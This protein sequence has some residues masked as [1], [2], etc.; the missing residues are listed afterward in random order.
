MFWMLWMCWE[1]SLSF[2]GCHYETASNLGCMLPVKMR[3]DSRWM[4]DMFGCIILDWLF[5]DCWLLL[6]VWLL[7]LLSKGCHYETANNLCCMLPVNKGSDP[8]LSKRYAHL[9]KLLQLEI[10][11]FGSESLLILSGNKNPKLWTSVFKNE[12]NWWNYFIKQ[13]QYTFYYRRYRWLNV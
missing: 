13:V 8:H 6:F 3:G 9:F 2:K 7:S 11:K 4:N 1:L 12:L 10:V 5:N